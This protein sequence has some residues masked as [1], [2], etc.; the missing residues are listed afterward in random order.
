MSEP[1]DRE[2]LEFA[3]TIANYAQPIA[4]DV[5]RSQLRASLL[6]APVAAPR[7]T[8]LRTRLPSLRPV[9][10]AVVVF[11]LLL[12][13]GGYAAA[14]SLPG[15]P[16]FA[17][18]R[19]TEEAQVALTA[20]DATRLD[21]RLTQA[22]R[23]VAD[24]RTVAAQHPGAT[25][26]AT[27]EYLAAAARVDDAL[28]AVL[29]QPTTLARA[30][31]IARAAETSQE[32]IAALEALAAQLPAEAQ[33][34]IGRAIDVQ[35]AVHGRAEGGSGRPQSPGASSA[36]GTSGEPPRGRP[37]GAPGG[38]PSDRGRPSAAPSRR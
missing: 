17:L 37:S 28:A 1:S 9:A 16:A 7:P 13:G 2:L 11:A 23:R 24:L 10:A 12:G 30:A 36:P 21:E 35:Q 6:S 31:A 38:Q 33:A 4:P 5:L 18:K 3:R 14:S 32:H 22:D 34:G 27:D 8:S 20:D 25:A 26:V 29:S 19:A 15:D